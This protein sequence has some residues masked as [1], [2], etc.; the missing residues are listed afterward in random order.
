ME[1]KIVSWKAISLQHTILMFFAGKLHIFLRRGFWGVLRPFIKFSWVFFA[2]NGPSFKLMT[3]LYDN[4]FSFITGLTNFKHNFKSGK[5]F[6]WNLTLFF[7][8]FWL[9]QLSKTPF[10]MVSCTKKLRFYPLLITIIIGIDINLYFGKILHRTILERR[11][12]FLLGMCRTY[13]HI[14]TDEQ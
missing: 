8:G 14:N 6:W 2:P 5:L 3:F 11:V 9:L 1:L 12:S 13:H 4:S 7:E 10:A